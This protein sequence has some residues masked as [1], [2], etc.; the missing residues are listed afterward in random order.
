MPWFCSP[1]SIP[2]IFT[3]VG[4]KRGKKNKKK[5]R[6][7]ER[8]EKFGFMKVFYCV[9]IFYPAQRLDLEKNST[10]TGSGR[11]FFTFQRQILVAF[12]ELQRRNLCEFHSGGRG[13]SKPQGCSLKTWW[14]RIS[15][16]TNKAERVTEKFSAV[17]W[18]R[19]PIFS[20]VLRVFHAPN[21]FPSTQLKLHS[22]HFCCL[23][24]NM[25][26]RMLRNPQSSVPLPLF[27]DLSPA[28]V[29]EI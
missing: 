20:P 4:G 16:G 24:Q 3:A 18:M 17:S 6:E 26:L 5:E 19:F 1:H 15:Q 27:P 8:G 22:L 21:L 29:A 2:Q 9:F 23:D 13:D 11:A 12:P 14:W 7:R 28:Q 10:K 25:G